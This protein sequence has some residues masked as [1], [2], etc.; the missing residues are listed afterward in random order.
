MPLSNNNPA[1][2]HQRLTPINYDIWY[3]ARPQRKLNHNIDLKASTTSGAPNA[4]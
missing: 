2:E 1:L 3:I 4:T